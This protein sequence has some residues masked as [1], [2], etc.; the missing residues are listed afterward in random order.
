MPAKA[1]KQALWTQYKMQ[2]YDK[3]EKGLLEEARYQLDQAVNE[4]TYR[5]PNNTTTIRTTPQ[6]TETHHGKPNN[7]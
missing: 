1:G 3:K 5:K 2:Q 4:E 6:Q 7:A